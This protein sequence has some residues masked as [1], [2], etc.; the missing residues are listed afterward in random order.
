MFADLLD[1]P[2]GFKCGMKFEKKNED[3]VDYIHSQP[4]KIYLSEVLAMDDDIDL[5][6]L[7]EQEEEKEAINLEKHLNNKTHHQMLKMPFEIII[8]ACFEYQ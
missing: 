3:Q 5:E 8:F 1:T 7:N 6:V 4:Q 2:P